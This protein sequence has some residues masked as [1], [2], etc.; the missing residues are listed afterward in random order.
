MQLNVYYN[1]KG[2]K[3]GY[4]YPVKVLVS[5]SLRD[6]GW[7]LQLSITKSGLDIKVEVSQQKCP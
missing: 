2:C 1:D 5:N 3:F 7:E 4:K 6:C